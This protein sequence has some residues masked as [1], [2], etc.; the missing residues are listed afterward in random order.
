MSSLYP[1]CTPTVNFMR[2]NQLS[3]SS[4]YKGWKFFSFCFLIKKI[5]KKMAFFLRY[6]ALVAQTIQLIRVEILLLA[7][8]LFDKRSKS[9][10]KFS[11]KTAQ[12]FF[13]I[14]CFGC[15]NYPA[16]QTTKGG[17][18]SLGHFAFWSKENILF[19]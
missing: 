1:N 12:H 15:S 2:T 17:N 19:S 10:R 11:Q 16:H 3:S 8:L 5:P 14:W 13:E 4:V 18:S 6:V 9:G 7:I